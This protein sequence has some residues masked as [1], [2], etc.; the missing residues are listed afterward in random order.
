MHCRVDMSEIYAWQARRAFVK[1]VARG[2]SGK[3]STGSTAVTG[4]SLSLHV[5][6]CHCSKGFA[7]AGINLAEAALQ[8]AAEDDAIVSHSSVQLPVHSFLNRISRVANDAN[9]LYLRELPSDSTPQ[10]TLQVSPYP[11][12]SVGLCQIPDL[13][14]QSDNVGNQ[15]GKSLLSESSRV[16]FIKVLDKALLCVQG[17][18]EVPV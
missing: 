13:L 2:E 10:Q 5:R 9:R 1:N 11:N 16:A 7:L 12:T 3:P 14:Y 18:P 15:T 4:K 17:N 8:V 6:L